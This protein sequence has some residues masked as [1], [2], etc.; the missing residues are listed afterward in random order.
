VQY[1]PMVFTKMN[2]DSTPLLFDAL[3]RGLNVEVVVTTSRANPQTGEREAQTVFTTSQ[4]AVIS[5][6]RFSADTMDQMPDL[7]EVEVTWPSLK[8][9]DLIEGTETEIEAASTR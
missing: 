7:V 9:E 5:A 4:R 1:G 6:V 8:I 2:D 3:A